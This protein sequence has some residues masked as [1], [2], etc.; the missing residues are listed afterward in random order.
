MRAR[1][2]LRRETIRMAIAAVDGRQKDARRPLSEEE[3]VTVIA[4]EQKRRREA[5]DAY[6]AAGREDLADRERSESRV[7]A[8]FLPAELSEEQLQTLVR[9]AILESGAASARD[10]GR[11]MTLLSPRTR[12]RA[13]GRA[14]SGMVAQELARLDLDTHDRAAPDAART[15]EDG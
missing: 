6:L 10:L 4:R 11:V 7:L 5:V 14:V 13:D 8:D 1:D 9:E 3:V 15:G 12:G 2:E